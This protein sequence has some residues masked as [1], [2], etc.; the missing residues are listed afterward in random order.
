MKVDEPAGAPV[1][2]PSA[3]KPGDISP[4]SGPIAGLPESGAGAASSPTKKSK[5]T[6]PSFEVLPNFSRVTPSQ[7][8]HIT[9]PPDGRYQPVRPVATTRQK[10]GS[11]KAASG[12]LSAERYAGGGGIL[13]LIDQRPGETVELMEFAVEERSIPVEQQG[14]GTGAASTGMLVDDNAPEADPPEPFEV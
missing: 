7:L 14:E 11:G 9:F 10:S 1:P 8:A 2:G 4:I 3:G 6:E 5:P 13:L 12:K